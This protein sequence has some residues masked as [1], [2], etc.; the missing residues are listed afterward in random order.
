M[1]KYIFFFCLFL[2][3]NLSAEIIKKL[4]VTGNNRI[5]QET[6][7]V[8]GEIN[9]NKDYSTFDVNKILKNLYQTE[10]FEDVKI[11]LNNGTLNI[12]VKEYSV[13]NFIDLRGEKSKTI[14]NKVLELLQ[15]KEKGSFIKSKLTKDVDT[16]KKIYASMGF[17]FSNVDSKI[18]RFDENRINLIYFLDKGKKTN[19]RKINFIGNKK[20]KEKRLRDVIASEEK[21]FW[22]VLSKNTFLNSNNIELDKRLLVNYYKAL[23][24]YDV[25]V[26]SNNAEVS[27]ENMTTLTYTINAGT[28]Y[29]V[30]KISANV[31][32]VLDKKTFLPLEKYFSKILGDY[33]S[34][35]KVKKLLDEVDL[36]IANND[37]QFIEHSVNEI[38]EG[39]TIEIKINIFEG[40]KELVERVNI[41]GNTVTDE[42]VLRSALLL[43]EGDPF[44]A[45]KLDQSVAKLKA[46]NI[47]SSVTKTIK[48]G[49]QKNQKIIE[50]TVDEK[51]TGEISAGAGIGTSGANFAFVVK[52]N[53]WLGKGVGVSTSVDIS[54]DSFT[55]GIDVNDPNY[56]FSGNSLSYFVRNTNNNKSNSGY[57]NNIIKTGIGT[58]FEQYKNIYLAPTLSF[59]YD[60]LKVKSDASESLKKQKGTFSDLSFDYRV[61]LD[62]RDRVFAPTS[63]YLSSFSQAIPIYADSP[64]IKNN[65]LLTSYKTLS[66][67]AIGAFKIY[68]SAI[69][70]LNNEDVRL[71]KRLFLPS[72]RLRGFKA[73][74]VGPKDGIDYVGANYVWAS[75]LEV[76]LPNLLPESTRTDIGLFLDVGN[77]W[78]VDYDKT[79]DDSN[80]VRSTAGLNTSWISPVGPMTFIFSQ[81]LAKATTDVTETFN[82][83]LGTTF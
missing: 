80:K 69:N 24:Y 2:N 25:Q 6:I 32:N 10:F 38:L 23:G 60:Q 71:S 59:S 83:R 13:V 29:R 66:P 33:Y 82:F 73:G 79:L 30:T 35:F 36:L 20:I 41:L 5:S 76:S 37:L 40:S 18:E 12:N 8:Y 54:P 22:K 31:S 27:S 17:N 65:Y 64:Y 63:G 67:D 68:T 58:S 39:E 48:E 46:K 14:K 55:G 45:L 51:P 9:L 16:I 50:I 75:N 57:K 72:S 1:F 70:G 21:K 3:F 28:R 81:N 15:I 78:G 42:S 61:S 49:T 4:I 47:F 52:E 11:S 77:I 74:Q 56:N 43:D 7:K 19:I 62:N 26:L 34:P 53:N 44:N